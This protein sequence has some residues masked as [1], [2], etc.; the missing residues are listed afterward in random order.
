VTPDEKLEIVKRHT[1]ALMEHFDSVQIFATKNDEAEETT[2]AFNHGNGNWY[3]RYGQIQEWMTQQS[4]RAAI[5]IR[6][7]DDR[8]EEP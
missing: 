2:Q 5:Q 1:A 7:E 8:E 3:A 6:K 4:E